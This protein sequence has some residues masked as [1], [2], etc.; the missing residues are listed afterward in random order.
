M[1]TEILSAL[2]GSG[3]PPP[4]MWRYWKLD[5]HAQAMLLLERSSHREHRR[6]DVPN[7]F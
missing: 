6:A 2:Y 7:L 5:H 1:K 4:P 3:E